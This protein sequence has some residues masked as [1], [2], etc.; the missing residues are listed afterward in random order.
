VVTVE[1]GPQTADHALA[2]AA[3]SL[4][5]IHC[6]HPAAASGLPKARS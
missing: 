4:S 2:I 1:G 6:H 3:C 5:V